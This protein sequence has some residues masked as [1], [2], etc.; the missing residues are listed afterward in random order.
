MQVGGALGL[1]VLATLSTSRTTNLVNAG[2]STGAAL[3]SGY[4]LAFVIG[5]GLLLAALAI[6]LAVLRSEPAA[7]EAQA[8]EVAEAE[9]AFSSEAL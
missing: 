9:P 3:T 1:A 6:A 8:V 4:R 5:A 7:D 2:D